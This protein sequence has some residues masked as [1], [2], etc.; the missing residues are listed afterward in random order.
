MKSQQK[1]TFDASKVT[2]EISANKIKHIS[3]SKTY[4][5]F[6]EHLICVIEKLSRKRDK[7]LEK[8]KA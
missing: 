6:T 7:K 5:Y 4:R 3:N 2:C 1:K 8:L